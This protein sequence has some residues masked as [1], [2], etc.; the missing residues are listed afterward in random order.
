[1][2]IVTGEFNING[3]PPIPGTFSYSG[4]GWGDFY[5]SP[6][7]RVW[8]CRTESYRLAKEHKLEWRY[9]DRLKSYTSVYLGD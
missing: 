3:Q 7:Q 1:M 5:L 4:F 8:C 9:Y 6:T 2:K